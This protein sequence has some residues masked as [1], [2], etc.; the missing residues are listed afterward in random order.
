MFDDLVDVKHVEHGIGILIGEAI[1]LR[2]IS[3]QRA[4]QTLLKLAVKMTTS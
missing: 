3:R 2:K 4:K 1:S